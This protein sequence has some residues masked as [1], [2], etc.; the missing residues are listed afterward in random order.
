LLACTGA[1]TIVSFSSYIWS[2]F[3]SWELVLIQ[4]ILSPLA[5]SSRICNCCCCCGNFFKLPIL[6]AETWQCHWE[7]C[8]AKKTSYRERIF[9]TL[10]SR[11]DTD[12]MII[13]V[14]CNIIAF[15]VSVEI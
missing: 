4:I 5:S 1:S 11:N 9:H 14:V 12:F 2:L 3:V 13:I 10:W 15:C 7:S 6:S 8:E